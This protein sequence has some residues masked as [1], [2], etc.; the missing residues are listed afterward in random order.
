MDS[1]FEA[2]Q[3]RVGRKRGRFCPAESAT[4]CLTGGGKTSR[5][6]PLRVGGKEVD[7]FSLASCVMCK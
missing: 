7:E 4:G 6:V 3:K 5:S 1:G 2:S